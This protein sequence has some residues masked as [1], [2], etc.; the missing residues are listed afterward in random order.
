MKKLLYLFLAGS[1]VFAA[2]K[3][4]DDAPVAINGC[5]ESTA[6]NYN[7]N[8]TNDDGSCTYDLVG[9]WTATNVVID[10]TLT[11]SY[12]G[13]T[14]D[15]LSSSGNRTLTT[16]MVGSPTSLEFMSNGTVWDGND[17]L[18]YT[19]NGTI[20]LVENVGGFH[21]SITNSNLSLTGAEEMDWTETVDFGNG[22]M[23]IDYYYLYSNTLNFTRNTSGIINN[24]ISQRAGNTNH[25]W[26]PKPK[27]PTILKDIK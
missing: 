13:E 17:T 24:N 6:T 2:C 18:D 16:Q 7:S 11:V 22:P 9:K 20:L 3:K 10:S 4:E 25:G 19:T 27:L 5:T 1:I 8:A 14:I 21:Y 15:S 26:L 23:E 12:M